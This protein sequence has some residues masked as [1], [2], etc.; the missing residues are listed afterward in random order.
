VNTK[1]ASRPFIEGR[2]PVRETVSDLRNYVVSEVFAT[3]APWK[4]KG[5]IGFRPTKP[6]TESSTEKG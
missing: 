4:V 2:W 5:E 1:I 3:F 6:K